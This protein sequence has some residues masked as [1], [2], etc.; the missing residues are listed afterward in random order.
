MISLVSSFKSTVLRRFKFLTIVFFKCKVDTLS[1]RRE[2]AII[3][4][5]QN[6]SISQH[7]QRRLVYILRYTI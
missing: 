4:I 7:E 6:E 3:G 1:G 2:K 5:S